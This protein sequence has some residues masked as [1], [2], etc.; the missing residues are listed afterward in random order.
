MKKRTF[1][2]FALFIIYSI[3]L[4]GCS[5]YRELEN[6][7]IM[8]GL[9]VDKNEQGKYIIT[10]EVVD[11]HEGG[12]D[13]KI[14]RKLI[15]CYGDTIV[16]TTSNLVNIISPKPDWGQLQI[17]IISQEVAREGI[18]DILDTLN[19][20][21]EARLT[22]DI[23]IS[24]EKTAKE[25]LDS[26]IIT[27]EMRSYEIEKML[28]EQTVSLSKIHRA[29]TYEIVNDLSEE[30]I[31][32]VLPAIRLI[33]NHGEKTAELSG[34]A[35]FDKDKLIGYLDGEETKSL[36]FIRDEINSGALVVDTH[37]GNGN[38]TL[39][40]NA[41]KTKVKPVYS[42]GEVSINIQIKTKVSLREYGIK[43]NFMDENEILVL[44]HAAEEK[45]KANIKNVIRKVQEDYDVDAF[46]F[47][48]TIYKDMPWLWKE[49]KPDWDNVF[50]SLDVNVNVNID[51]RNQGLILKPIKVGN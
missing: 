18:I 9:A 51:I 50:K 38:V 47:G 39:V 33:E 11:L 27:T 32:P 46:G 43:K 8:A 41:S 5:S 17:I 19:R 40:I 2:L 31:S 7:S 14:K 26:Q 44:K 15:E 29:K 45:L 10:A 1:F 30:G 35:V 4:T 20:H 34:S 22:I 21:N 49:I 25:I 3:L 6:L 48:N 36:L 42:N 37:P 12:K 16:D 13:V 23:L 28:D 24:K